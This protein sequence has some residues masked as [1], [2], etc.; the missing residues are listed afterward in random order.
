MDYRSEASVK[1]RLTIFLKGMAMGVADSV[2]G[3]SG[4]TIAVMVGIYEELIHSLKNLNPVLLPAHCKGGARQFWININGGFLFSLLFG[5]VTS[6][7][8]SANTVLYLLEFQYPLVMAFFSGLVFASTW[9]LRKQITHW[10][11]R[12]FGFLL[13]GIALTLL[14]SL[15]NP[16]AGTFNYF[17]LFFCGLI[18]I[19][20]MILPGISGAFIL[21]LLGVY[22]HVLSALRALDL[23]VI[24]VF[25][26]GCAIGLLSFAHLLSWTFY[27]YRQQTYS[28]LTGMLAASIVVLWP[29]KRVS[30][31]ESTEVTYLSPA[32]FEAATGQSSQ[33]LSV[34]LLVVVGYSVVA[35]FE[36][37]TRVRPS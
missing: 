31:G 4:G 17:Y 33:L 26:S 21:I 36:R 35:I 15:A 37:I 5:I 2:P 14:I 34:I 3:V 9:F 6:L 10:Q 8:L 18:A 13:L 22:D 12:E 23:G 25:A 24:F 19:C 16:M 32:G 27:H 7:Y 11:V 30:E 20:A 28:F 29:W 1:G